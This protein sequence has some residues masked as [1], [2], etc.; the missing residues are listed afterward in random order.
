VLVDGDV[1]VDAGRVVLPS[2]RKM[3]AVRVTTPP[4][5]GG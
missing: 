5:A 1:V 4:P 3:P 2:R